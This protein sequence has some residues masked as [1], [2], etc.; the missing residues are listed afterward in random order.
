[1]IFFSKSVG[2][3][4]F[5]GFIAQLLFPNEILLYTFSALLGLGSALIWIGQGNFITLNSDK[6]TIE[7]NSGIFLAMNDASNVI[8]NAFVFV[9]FRG[10]DDID[11]YL[12]TQV[13]ILLCFQYLTDF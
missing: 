8:G 11:S 5:V 13:S 9:A 4:S 1:M 6:D 7:R 2:G 10:I 12:R 3:L